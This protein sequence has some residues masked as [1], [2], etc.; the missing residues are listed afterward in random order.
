MN[1]VQ[2][3]KHI[4]LRDSVLEASLVA[5]GDG[6]ADSVDND[7][8]VRGLD[9]DLGGDVALGVGQVRSDLR[10][11]FSHIGVFSLVVGGV[12]LR[13]GYV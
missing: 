6:G 12:R 5:T 4:A 3:S 7:H 9:A 10:E 1:R 8:V 2:T 13:V 11:T